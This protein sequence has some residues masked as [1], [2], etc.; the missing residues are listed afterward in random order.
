MPTSGTMKLQMSMLVVTWFSFLGFTWAEIYTSVGHM[1]SLISLE[2]Q[3]LQSLKEYILL[4]EARLSMMKSWADKRDGLDLIIPEDKEDLGKLVDVYKV[5]K[6]LN[7]DWSVVES[8]VLEEPSIEFAARLT[9]MRRF[10]PTE[11]DEIGAAKALLLLQRTYKLD[12]KAL[13]QGILPG[14]K[15]RALMSVSDCF[16]LGQTAYNIS[17][18]HHSMLWMKQALRQLN[19]GEQSPISKVQVLDYLINVSFQLGDL[20]RSVDFTHQL[21][22]LDYSHE[23]AQLN[24]PYFVKLLEEEKAGK[25]GNGGSET[26]QESLS[27]GQQKHLKEQEVYE[28][29]CRGEGVK[30]TPQKQKRLF[31]RYHHG[32]KMPQL[33]I[34]PFKE[35][36]EWD[37][38]HIVRYH[39]VMSDEEIKRIKEIA[40]PKLRR[41][42]IFASASDFVESDEIRV[43]QSVFLEEEEDPVIGQVNRRIQII[44]GLSDKTAELLQVAD[45]GIGGFFR[46]HLDYFLGPGIKS[47]DIDGIGDR[48]ATFLS[49]MSDVEAGGA[50]VFPKLGAVFSPKKGTALFWYNLLRS[51]KGNPLTIHAACPVLAGCKWGFLWR[52]RE[53]ERERS[54]SPV[55]LRSPLVLP[56]P[57]LSV[58]Q[59]LTC[60]EKRQTRPLQTSTKSGRMTVASSS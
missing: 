39:D 49:Y 51:G 5:L 22:S 38:P 9:S 29:L 53:R 41:S 35:E 6:H 11:E 42:R 18:F 59:L 7:K 34:A 30:L 3:L 45:Y 36:D 16:R 33:L 47:L 23:Q 2:R 24:L 4:N 43:S 28:S 32:N 17:D 48:V 27:S 44:T 14:T 55:G 40:K 25:L 13:S 54:I 10:F 56:C 26:K 57:V 12:L 19:T 60:K 52:L 21:L 58:S 8:F 50:T 15:Y 31:C 46:P 1:A 20:Y 37:T